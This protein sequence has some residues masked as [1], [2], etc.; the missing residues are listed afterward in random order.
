[1]RFSVLLPASTCGKQLT[2][3]VRNG[4]FMILDRLSLINY[5]NIAGAELKFSP[6]INCLIGKN[7]EGK[8]NVL[9][10]IY[11]MSF[12]H[13]A[14][15]NL[16]ALV[17][18]HGED[19]MM[20][21][22]NYVNDE[23]DSFD[24]ACGVKPHKSKRFCLNKKVYKRFAEHIGLIPLVMVS[25][26]DVELVTGGSDARRK[27][28]DIVISQYDRLYLDSLIKYNRALK[29]RN[30]LLKADAEPDV[31]MLEIYEEEMAVE[32]ERIFAARQ[33]L[34]EKLT[35]L[36]QKYYSLISVD[37]E[38]PSLTY[39]SHCQ[40]GPLYETI[41]NGRGKDRILGYSLH[42]VHR[43]ELQ[44]CLGEYPIRNE[45]SQG[46]TKS[47]LLAL[48][49]AQFDLLRHSGTG[50]VPLL[51]LDDLFDKLDASRV[52]QIV[53]MVAGND[54]G[55][56]FITDT[57]RGKLSPILEATEQDYRVFNVTG[58]EVAL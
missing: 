32:G 12:C 11:Y 5:K 3:H 10:A 49:F 50:S 2:S 44:M 51:L 31:A 40:R 8:T 4:V 56:I 36:F 38:R 6:K 58:G 25:P 16:D 52:S 37:K 57:D 55:Q 27:F 35:P 14:T 22:G 13:S 19:Y 29:Q 26:N 41:R 9:D 53:N 15:T 1:M 30:V 24:V 20:V 47:F 43:D 54:F 34:A 45:G 39:V 42:G 18:K 28:M 48:K 46:Q 21:Q 7:G 33:I 23:G 17:V